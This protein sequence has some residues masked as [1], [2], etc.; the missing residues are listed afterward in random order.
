[1]TCRRPAKV[2]RNDPCPCGSGRKYK[3]C[4]N[5]SNPKVSSPAPQKSEFTGFISSGLP[6]GAFLS[7]PSPVPSD[8]PVPV[9]YK[10]M[11]RRWA[12]ALINVGSIRIGTLADFRK[13]EAHAAGIGDE[14]EGTITHVSGRDWCPSGDVDLPGLKLRGLAANMI[15]ISNLGFRC[16][17]DALIL[18]FTA[19]RGAVG[20]PSEYNAIVEIL[21]TVR[22]VETITRSLRKNA[23]EMTFVALKR[24][25]YSDRENRLDRS[26]TS[27]EWYRKPPR[28]AEQVEYRAAWSPSALL[29]EEGL[30]AP[31][32][33]SPITLIEP[34]LCSLVRLCSP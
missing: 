3:K 19:D 34:E 13:E 17:T 18:C 28:F 27:D 21:D 15:T 24:C 11:E 23:H 6:G 1:V 9:L 8:S 2:G 30:T 33:I 29:A 4:H 20:F 14:G 32:A 16:K 22:F 31:P 26:T 5:G 25:L 12:E 10:L 7:V